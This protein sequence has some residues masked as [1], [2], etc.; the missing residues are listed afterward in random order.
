MGNKLAKEKLFHSIDAN[1]RA[2]VRIV[3]NKYPHLINEYFDSKKSSMPLIRAVWLGKKEI[4]DLLLEFGADPNLSLNNGFNSLFVAA[5]R[6]HTKIIELL[7]Q[8]GCPLD[9]A[10]N[11]GFSPL[12][13]AIIN[14][15]YN[16]SLALV[17]HVL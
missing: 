4:V 7:I 13:I 8:K 14:G 15:Y 9:V 11:L 5:S 3:L 1:N 6:G 2:D 16:A 17:N 12:D 10:D